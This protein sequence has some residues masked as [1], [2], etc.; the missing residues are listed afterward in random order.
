MSAQAAESA[1]LTI[2]VVVLLVLC[3]ARVW[4]AQ[5]HADPHHRDPHLAV[6]AHRL[7]VVCPRRA[8]RQRGLCKA[9]AFDAWG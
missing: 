5:S 9:H 3:V 8:A 6:P 2:A 4:F 1:P 7:Q